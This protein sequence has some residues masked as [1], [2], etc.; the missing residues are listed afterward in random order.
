LAAELLWHW[1]GNV[2]GGT[3]PMPFRQILQKGLAVL[4]GRRPAISGAEDPPFFHPSLVKRV[5]GVQIE[6]AQPRRFND[7]LSDTLYWHLARQSLPALLHYEDRNSMAFSIE[8]RVPYLD[9]RI[10]EFA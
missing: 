10:V 9:Y 1:G 5:D 6:R 3:V 2:L 7:L 8:A 4:R